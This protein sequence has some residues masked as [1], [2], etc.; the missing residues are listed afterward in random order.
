MESVVGEDGCLS[1][2]TAVAA[3]AL[4]VYLYYAIVAPSV[5]RK[6]AKLEIETGKTNEQFRLGRLQAE[7][8]SSSWEIDEERNTSHPRSFVREEIQSYLTYFCVLLIVLLLFKK[9][10]VLFRKLNLKL[11]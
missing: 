8:A 1:H 6:H 11:F 9:R 4:G 10:F 7:E 2:K 5:I 3:G